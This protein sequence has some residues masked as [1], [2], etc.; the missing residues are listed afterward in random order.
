MKQKR[1][2]TLT[3]DMTQCTE[4]RLRTIIR[5]LFHS[6]PR[7]DWSDAYLGSHKLTPAQIAEVEAEIA[8]LYRDEKRYG[9]KKV[10]V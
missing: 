8:E 4:C 3:H 5:S 6:R 7:E 2:I 1:E 9:R 10:R